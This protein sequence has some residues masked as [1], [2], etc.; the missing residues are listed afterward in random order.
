[1]KTTLEISD[2]LFRR[3]RQLADREGKTF[4]AIVEESLSTRLL[5]QES[6]VTPYILEIPV[7]SGEITPEFLNAPW[8]KIRDAIYEYPF[9][10]HADTKTDVKMANISPTT[11]AAPGKRRLQPQSR[12]AQKND[13]R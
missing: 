1:M 5:V 11:T 8:E 3:A 4:R 6:S 7:V 12:A 10:Q 13:R 9:G 2:S